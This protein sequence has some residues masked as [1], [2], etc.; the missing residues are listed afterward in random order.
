LR[1]LALTGD[2]LQTLIQRL[3][4]ARILSDRDLH[5]SYELR[6]DSLARKVWER[7]S[8]REKELQGNLTRTRRADP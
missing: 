7:M 6:H 8:A 5:G 4:A 2:D 3:I 1:A